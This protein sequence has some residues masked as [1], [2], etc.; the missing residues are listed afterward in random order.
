[1][2]SMCSLAARRCVMPSL[3]DSSGIWWFCSSRRCSVTMRSV[4]VP[5]RPRCRSCSM[6]HSCRSRAATPVGSKPCTSRSALLDAVDRPGTHRGDLARPR[7][8]GYPSSSRLPMMAVP[9]ARSS[10]SSVCSDSCHSRW[11]VSD[12]LVDSVFSIGGS[13]LTSV[14]RPRPVAV[15]EVVAEEVLVVVVVPGVGLALGGP[16]GVLLVGLV[17]GRLGL[18]WP[19]DPPTGISSSRGFSTTSWLS[20]SASSSVDIGSSLIACCSDGVRM[21]FCDEL[22]VE[23]LLNGHG[24]GPT[25]GPVRAPCPRSILAAEAK[26]MP[27]FGAVPQT[28]QAVNP[29]G[30]RPRDRSAGPLRRRPARPA[31]RSGRSPRR[32][33]CTRDR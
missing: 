13:S 18:G 8:P 26:T 1:M 22:R 10:G 32:A 19:A 24:L 21:S 30:N 17:G 9:I 4:G 6:R 3:R 16:L 29:A 12:E 25:A 31:C 28:D 14:G 15:V 23:F 33:R 2:T 5:S 27:A 20:R 11:S 7:R